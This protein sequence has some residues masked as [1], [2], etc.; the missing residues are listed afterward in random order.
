MSLIEELVNRRAQKC[1]Q[2][3]EYREVAKKW[4]ANALRAGDELAELDAAIAAL[5]V[6]TAKPPGYYEDEINSSAPQAPALADNP[7]SQELRTVTSAT[8]ESAE[9]QSDGPVM[10]GVVPQD[11]SFASEDAFEAG[12]AR[13]MLGWP[14]PADDHYLDPL[15]SIS[16]QEGWDNARNSE[17]PVTDYNPPT[18]NPA[19]EPEPNYFTKY[20]DDPSLEHI[21]SVERPIGETYIDPITDV[22]IPVKQAKPEPNRYFQLW[23]NR[24]KDDAS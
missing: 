24:H 11:E 5:G 3:E 12:A 13:Y 19:P 2:V 7:P 10:V 22:E 14:R 18:D 21:R 15:L 20:E 17:M 16:A 9:D 1:E 23:A 6:W 4:Q 8:V